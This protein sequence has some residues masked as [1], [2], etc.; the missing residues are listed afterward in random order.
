MIIVISVINW[1]FLVTHHIFSQGGLHLSTFIIGIH[2][3]QE[4]TII[5]IYILKIV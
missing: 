2:I 3:F 4:P 1:F 5:K